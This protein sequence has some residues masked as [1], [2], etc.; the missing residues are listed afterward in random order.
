M[1]NFNIPDEGLT[2]RIKISPALA[3]Q[4]QAEMA[5]T[6]CGESDEDGDIEV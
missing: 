3:R 4:L 1:Q 6:E 2:K 5:D